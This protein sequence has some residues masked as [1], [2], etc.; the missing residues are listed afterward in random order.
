MSSEKEKRRAAHD[1]LRREAAATFESTLP[2]ARALFEDLFDHLDEVLEEEE[3]DD[4]LRYTKA[5]LEESGV[6]DPARVA[7]WLMAHGGRCDC[8]V[9]ARVQEQFDGN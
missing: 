9:L 8:E 1:F 5:F 2:M 6:A 3:C 7:A 4:T